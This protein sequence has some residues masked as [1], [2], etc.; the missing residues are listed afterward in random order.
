MQ[1]LLYI[2]YSNSIK[3]KFL[4][5]VTFKLIKTSETEGLP[6]DQ[7]RHCYEIETSES[8]VPGLD[9]SSFLV[10]AASD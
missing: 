6:E 4:R 9:A 1:N 7:H 2:T 5:Q 10:F 3:V 8:S